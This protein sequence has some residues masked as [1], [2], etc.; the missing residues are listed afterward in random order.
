MSLYY[1]DFGLVKFRKNDEMLTGLEEDEVDNLYNDK[2]FQVY[3][4]P[5]FQAFKTYEPTAAG[6]VYSFAIILVEIA[7][8]NDPYGV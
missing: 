8:R 4:S 6:D 7:T 2:R 3:K 1:L 5:E